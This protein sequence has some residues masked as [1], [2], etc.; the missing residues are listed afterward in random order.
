M[1]IIQEVIGYGALLAVTV[2]S[3]AF[4]LRQYMHGDLLERPASIACARPGAS[5][6]RAGPWNARLV[7]RANGPRHAPGSRHGRR[8]ARHAY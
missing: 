8:P 6:Q 7:R 3:A 1:P 5:A 2:G 4:L